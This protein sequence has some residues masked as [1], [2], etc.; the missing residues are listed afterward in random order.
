M[1]LRKKLNRQIFAC[2]IVAFLCVSGLIAYSV[3]KHA[4]SQEEQESEQEEQT[5]RQEG[6]TFRRLSLQDENGVIDPNGL[7]KARQH[8]AE[9]KKVQ[10]VRQSKRQ[11]QLEEAGIAPDSWTW[12]GPGN[13]G[14]RIRSISINPGD[15]NDMLVGSVSG[16]IWRTLNGAASWFPVS[17]FIANL[18]VSTLA[19][20]P[21][22][23]NIIYAGTGESSAGDGIQGAGIFR[24][25][26]GG[27]LWFRV[28]STNNA[29]FNF[30][31]RLSISLDGATILAGTGTGIWR[32][33]DSGGTWNLIPSFGGNIEDVDFDPTNSL[34][35]IAAR[36]GQTAYSIDG[37]ANW[38]FSRYSTDG[39]VTYT[40]AITGRVEIA[41]APSNPLVV[42]ASVD[43]NNGD[44]FW[45]GDGGRNYI[46]VNTGNNLMGG[47]GSYDNI[48]WVNP[49]DPTFVIVGGV[50][51]YRSTNSGTTFSDISS[52]CNPI[53]NHADQHFIAAPPTFNNTSNRTVFFANDGGMYRADNVATVCVSSA[54]TEL[55]NNLGITQFYGV[56]GNLTSGV[57]IG[58]TQDNG[59]P[60]YTGGT[61]N[62]TQI[63]RNDGGYVAADQTD[64]NYFYGE[65]QNMGV[66]R[67]FNGGQSVS[68]ISGLE[69]ERNNFRTNFIAPLVIDPNEP[70][71]LLAGGWSLWR[72]NDA[73]G[74]ATWNAIKNPN[75]APTPGGGVGDQ[76]S[77]SAIAINPN[78]S[79][80]VVV[81][82]NNGDVY[83]N[84]NAT[85]ANP[86]PNWTKIDT[87]GL[88]DRMVTRLT[89]DP[90][91]G[92]NWIYAT[93]GGFNTDNV[94]V[95]RN[96]G[97]AW[98]D[99][100]GAT[101]TSTDLP[102]VP[103]RSLVFHPSNAN[104]LYVGT[105]MGIFTS[106]DAGATWDLPQ[107]GPA[108]VSV[109]ELIWMG[110]DLI[111]ATHG[112]GIYRAS[113]GFYV[114][115]NYLGAQTGAFLQPFRTVNAAINA[116]PV[117]SYRAIWLKPNC[118]FYVEQINSTNKRFE[119]RSLGG[120]IRIGP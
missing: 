50:A 44:V 109:D 59:T 119:F 82:H 80:F 99:V 46:R 7:R 111:A 98:I 110:G 40:A 34:R 1:I 116:L 37:G 3:L 51:L 71:R 91:R 70:T 41:Y 75:N 107:N 57:I 66:F 48:I 29:N 87:A 117:N 56:A 4:V 11:G 108:N 35:A 12:L 5:R 55:N 95:T 58:G 103:V 54:W 89:W 63:D 33:T 2:V 28:D 118:N 14:G 27:G 25:F 47:Q 22:N 21:A 85:N 76:K 120:T 23:P 45:S 74:A 67:S 112:R 31:N 10:K 79:D 104:L 62:W 93:F 16:G 101:A 36:G 19:R 18:A 72:T 105:E 61:E 90:N 68:I 13:I 64:P 97:T 38:I 6:L 106:P 52:G 17:D 115:C 26:D 73:R 15:A 114:D 113:G 100:S 8:I 49:L 32:S 39:G 43:Q 81:G 65:I 86:I 88:P 69:A 102:A 42:Y 78:N 84:L 20:S 77:I 94:Y 92:P 9:M 96:L 53:P 24:S 30:V 60:R 83:L